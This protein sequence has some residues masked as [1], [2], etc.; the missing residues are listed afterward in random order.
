M[1]LH[2]ELLESKLTYENRRN[3]RMIE[4]QIKLNSLIECLQ[5][6]QTRAESICFQEKRKESKT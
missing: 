3:L 1:H 6:Y 4:K 2:L 5:L